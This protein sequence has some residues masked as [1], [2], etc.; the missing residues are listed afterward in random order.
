MSL[1]VRG[2]ERRFCFGRSTNQYHR[3]FRKTFER[4]LHG[5]H[6]VK[7]YRV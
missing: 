3:K 5:L 4:T 1:V 7:W 2:D 6:L